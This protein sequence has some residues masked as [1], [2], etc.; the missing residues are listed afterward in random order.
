M[1]P[2][3]RHP[4]GRRRPAAI[5]LFHAAETHWVAL[6]PF[7]V[8]GNRLFGRGVQGARA[9]RPP[10]ANTSRRPKAFLSRH[11]FRGLSKEIQ[12]FVA[13]LSSTITSRTARTPRGRAPVPSPTGSRNFPNLGLKGPGICGST[14]DH[15]GT[16]T[17]L[18]VTPRQAR[19]RVRG[20][21][22]VKTLQANQAHLAFLQRR[23]HAEG[24]APG[25]VHTQQPRAR[26]ARSAHACPA[27][28]LTFTM[29]VDLPHQPSSP[30]RRP[31]SP[32]PPSV[33]P[34]CRE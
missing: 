4:A 19:R 5:Q 10:D 15:P 26:P 12:H 7:F 16:S 30:D 21:L 20:A 31:G 17:P 13:P 22:S 3:T 23:Q 9:H 33:R 14:R 11:I 1:R 34:P 29:A 27:R 32:R 6:K 28:P 18:R 24:A 25:P 8:S 2:G